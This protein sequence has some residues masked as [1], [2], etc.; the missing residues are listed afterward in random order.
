[1]QGFFDIPVDNLRASP[2]LIRHIRQQMEASGVGR[3]QVVIVARQSSS[4]RK[5]TAYS[6]RLKVDL[7]ILNGSQYDPEAQIA[8]G[9]SS[10]PPVQSIELVPGGDCL[11]VFTD[12]SNF[13]AP[14]HLV[15]EVRGKLAI[16]LDDIVDNVDHFIQAARYLKEQGATQVHLVATHALFSPAAAER[17]EASEVDHIVVTNTGE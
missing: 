16:L 13:R 1:M 14:I 10:P 7:A 12:S 15:G 5:A 4:V 3:D 2:F 17:L 11:P 8:D 9:R 6:Q